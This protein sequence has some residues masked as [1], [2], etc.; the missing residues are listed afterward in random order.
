MRMMTWTMT[1]STK[2]MMLRT[3][4]VLV[5]YWPVQ[6]NS[7]PSLRY[8]QISSRSD[9]VII[10]ISSSNCCDYSRLLHTNQ[11]TS[12]SKIDRMPFCMIPDFLLQD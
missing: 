10:E 9:I 3:R 7:D 6:V 8:D 4:S 12:P 1:R 2:A 11:P 5:K